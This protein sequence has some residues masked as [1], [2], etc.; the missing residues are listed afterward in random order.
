MPG[1]R[2]STAWCARSR[3]R[4]VNSRRWVTRCGSS[5]RSNSARCLA[6]P[7]PRSA[8]RCF[9]RAASTGGFASSIPTCCTSPPKVRWAGGAPLRVAQR[10]PVHDGLS[11]ALSRV[12]TRA[13]PAAAVLE[14][15]VA[16]ALPRT[17][18]GRDGAD[19]GGGRRSGGQWFHQREALVARRGHGH[20]PSAAEQAARQHAADLPVRRPRGGREERRSVPRA[21][22]AR[23]EVGGGHGAGARAHPRALSAA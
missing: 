23:I 22:P 1:S 15:R 4:R 7:T 16:A 20:L 18:E 2:R 5:R 13:P 9:R 17:I 10:F 12:R 3:P 11:H 19:A 6:R 8:C 21:R 14:L